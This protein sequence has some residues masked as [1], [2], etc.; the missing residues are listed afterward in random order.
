MIFW[1]KSS[2]MMDSRVWA[3]EETIGSPQLR[4]MLLIREAFAPLVL[5]SLSAFFFD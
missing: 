1:N 5:V 4:C 2:K 3:L